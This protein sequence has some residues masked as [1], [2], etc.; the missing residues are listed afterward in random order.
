MATAYSGASVS[1]SCH[2]QPAPRAC[3][4]CARGVHL[5][6]AFRELAMTFGRAALLVIFLCQWC[7]A[8]PLIWDGFVQRIETGN[9]VI[10]AKSRAHDAPG[11]PVSFYGVQAPS[12]R[13]PFGPEAYAR[14]MQLMPPGTPVTVKGAYTANSGI[15]SALVQVSGSSVNYLLVTEGL[16]WV[17]RQT[18]KAIFCRRWHLEENKAIRARRGIWSLNV[19]TPPWQWGQ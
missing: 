4:G 1:Y 15:V 10:V 8:E 18:C 3:C 6:Y 12:S 13:Q 17:D 14:L 16:A 9:T 19:G 11:V 5:G 2:I 7:S